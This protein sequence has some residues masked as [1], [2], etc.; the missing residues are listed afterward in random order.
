MRVTQLPA[1]SV[2]TTAPSG[3]TTGPSG[4]P[5]FSATMRTSA[6]LVPPVCV[7]RVSRRAATGS[8]RRAGLARRAEHAKDRGMP[9]DVQRF[10]SAL[11]RDASDA[12]VYADKEGVIRFWNA[13]AARIFG[14]SEAEAMG[15]S[16]DLIIPETLRARHWTG[17]DKTMETGES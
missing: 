13:G 7:R 14:F 15:Q 1:I 2:S 5:K 12:I 16:L 8:S 3:I 17:F 6:M 11:V 10:A 9:L 4:K